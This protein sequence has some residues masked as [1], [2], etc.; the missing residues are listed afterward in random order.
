MGKSTTKILVI[1]H[2]AAANGRMHV[3]GMA[4]GRHRGAA[5]A[6]AADVKVPQLVEPV[7][8]LGCE[9]PPCHPT[10][11]H[12]NYLIKASYGIYPQQY[13]GDT[14]IYHLYRLNVMR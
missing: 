7:G 14:V 13:M 6:D 5:D 3:H 10:V 12:P 4:Q 2:P 11:G 1:L 8:F 9:D